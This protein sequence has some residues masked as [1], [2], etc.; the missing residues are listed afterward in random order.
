VLVG[1]GVT[2]LS[3]ASR[4]LGRV[5]AKLE[6]L[7]LAECERAAAAAIGAPSADAARTA[8]AAALSGGIG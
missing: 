8:A 4:S 1:L 2:S 6:Q 3:M 7:S 5:S